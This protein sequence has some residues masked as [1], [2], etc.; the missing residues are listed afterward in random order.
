MDLDDE[1]PPALVNVE[2]NGEVEDSQPRVPI[3]IVTGKFWAA[4]RSR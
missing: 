3:T 4:I 2:G 1:E